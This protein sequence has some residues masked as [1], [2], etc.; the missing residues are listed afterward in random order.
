MEHD[1]STNTESHSA[2]KISAIFIG[3]LQN[4]T[5]ESHT[6]WPLKQLNSLQHLHF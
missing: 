4:V 6:F 5:A 3:T 1:F 2:Q